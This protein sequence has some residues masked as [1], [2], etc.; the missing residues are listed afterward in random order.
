MGFKTLARTV[1]GKERERKL[2]RFGKTE[3]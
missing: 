2:V 3:E 1:E